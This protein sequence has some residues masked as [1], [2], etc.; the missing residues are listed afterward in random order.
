MNEAI[1]V[2]IY[3]LLDRSGSMGQLRSDVIGGFNTWLGTEQA[4][5]GK[6]RFTM[7]QFDTEGPFDVVYDAIPLTEVAP[8]TEAT[9]I[10]R[11][12]T[13][14][15]DAEGKLMTRAYERETQRKTKDKKAEAILVV[16]YTD[17][18]ENSS[19]EW[20]FENIA[21]L[22][23]EREATGWAFAYLGVGHDGYRQAQRIGTQRAS[24][25]SAERSSAGV[26][27]T[28]AGFTTATRNVRDNAGRGDVTHSA[29]LFTEEDES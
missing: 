7:V 6:C 14:L 24:T 15:L 1:P 11:G 10:P 17:G 13:P 18:E 29:E 12:G 3:F 9:Y 23:K 28:Y 25:M 8:L 2:H 21:K 20:S 19:S 4:K 27:Q 22:K 26:A 5:P 16:T